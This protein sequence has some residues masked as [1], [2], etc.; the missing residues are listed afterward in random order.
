MQQL[1]SN[2]RILEISEQTHLKYFSPVSVLNRQYNRLCFE[3]FARG[4]LLDAGA[5]Y[6]R[7]KELVAPYCDHYESMDVTAVVDGL[8]YICD[9]QDMQ[10]IPSGRY[11]TVLLT[12]IVEHLPRPDDALR[13][14]GRVLKPEGILIGSTPHLSRLH[15]EPYDYFRFTKYGLAYL[16]QHVAQFGEWAVFPAGGLLSFL[17]HQFSTLFICSTLHLPVIGDLLARFNHSVVVQVILAVDR[18]LD[19]QRK[20]ACMY[21]FVGAK[22]TFT[23]MQ[24]DFIQSIPGVLQK[25][26]YL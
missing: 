21:F 11:D 6:L 3:H 8:D 9:V 24:C 15:G 2:R 22:S 20:M 25:G 7:N 17:G 19:I 16:L 23:S 18:R 14:C 26:D 10:C 13:E 1:R 4:R 5:G 12:H